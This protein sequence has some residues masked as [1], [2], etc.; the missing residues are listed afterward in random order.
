MTVCSARRFVAFCNQTY[1]L[2][3][4]MEPLVAGRHAP[5]HAWLAS[6]HS[7][8]S[9]SF[10]TDDGVGLKQVHLLAFPKVIQRKNTLLRRLGLHPAC[11][12]E[13]SPRTHA[14]TLALLSELTRDAEGTMQLP[15]TALGRC[16]NRHIEACAHIGAPNGKENFR[17][18]PVGG[19]LPPSRSNVR[20]PQPRKM[21]RVAH[22]L[23]R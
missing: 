16:A 12:P 4:T 23:Q 20:L 7:V 3:C 18:G 2:V 9:E 21:S 5:Y 11:P 6:A 1:G 22:F 10:P 8:T 15:N 19:R 14:A 13:G 17:L